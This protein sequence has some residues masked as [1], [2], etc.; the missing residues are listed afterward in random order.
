MLTLN[1][2]KRI[3]CTDIIKH[4]Y[5]RDIRSIIPPN[6]YNRYEQDYMTK[7]PLNF[8]GVGQQKHPRLNLNTK[9]LIPQISGANLGFLNGSQKN[10]LHM[11]KSTEHHFIN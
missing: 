11:H 5:F 9:Y 8:K 6:V 10:K 2:K 3:S 7:K 1:P 4:E